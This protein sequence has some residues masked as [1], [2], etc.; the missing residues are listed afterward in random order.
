MLTVSSFLFSISCFLF[1]VF[2]YT[3]YSSAPLSAIAAGVG[4]VLYTLNVEPSEVM[5]R[6]SGRVAVQDATADEAVVDEECP[7]CK[8]PQ[9]SYHTAQL[10]GL[11]E[12]QTIFYSCLNKS[13]GHKFNLNS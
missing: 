11:D 2:S 9:L 12:G 6:L 1:G 5:R 13:C 4:E 7:V 3:L 10:R 8:H